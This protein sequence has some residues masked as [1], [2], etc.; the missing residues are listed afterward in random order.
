[1]PKLKVQ[2][3]SKVQI[4]KLAQKRHPHMWAFWHSFDIWTLTFEIAWPNYLSIQVAEK[5]FY[6]KT[7]SKE[8]CKTT[9]SLSGISGFFQKS[10]QD[11]QVVPIPAW[12]H[13]KNIFIPAMKCVKNLH[14]NILRIIDDAFQENPGR[15]GR[16]AQKL[17]I[18][19]WENNSTKGLDGSM[20]I[21]LKFLGQEMVEGTG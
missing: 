14:G 7:F 15:T 5:N 21:D 4:T 17:C 20:E 3:K 10:L 18:L 9:L 11:P 13:L 6:V 2:M 19:P 1:M 16:E 8:L 12:L